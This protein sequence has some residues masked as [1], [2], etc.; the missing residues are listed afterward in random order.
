MGLAKRAMQ[1]VCPNVTLR[2]TYVAQPQLPELRNNARSPAL[3]CPVL[4]PLFPGPP[5]AGDLEGMLA[6]V[7]EVLVAKTPVAAARHYHS[8]Q[9]VCERSH[10]FLQWN[11]CLPLPCAT[12]TRAHKHA[13]KIAPGR[14][15]TTNRIGLGTSSHTRQTLEWGVVGG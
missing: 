5:G 1:F 7:K 10:C 9:R 6:L 8:L 2:P 11:G 3:P 12:G 14:A 15:A 4:H 13:D